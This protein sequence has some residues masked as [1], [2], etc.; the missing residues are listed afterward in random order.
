MGQDV[1]QVSLTSVRILGVSVP[2]R[3]HLFHGQRDGLGTLQAYHFRLL[4]GR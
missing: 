2:V 4:E 1:L 3:S